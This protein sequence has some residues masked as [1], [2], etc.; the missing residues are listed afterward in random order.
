VS[1]PNAVFETFGFS[2]INRLLLQSGQDILSIPAAKR[3][4]FNE[5][6]IRF[7]ESSEATG[8]M[9]FLSRCQIRSKFE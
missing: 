1:H 4:E 7:Y 3:Q 8:M 5:K 9:A 2:C 6:M